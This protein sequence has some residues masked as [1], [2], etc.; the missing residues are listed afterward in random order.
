MPTPE[1][2]FVEKSKS[3][4]KNLGQIEN[5]SRWK[6]SD[7]FLFILPTCKIDIQEV[8]WDRSRRRVQVYPE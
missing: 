5:K 8:L 2:V 3:Q 7:Y 4:S 6:G 1:N